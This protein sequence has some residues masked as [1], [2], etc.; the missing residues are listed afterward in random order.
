MSETARSWLPETAFSLDR[1]RRAFDAIVGGW[2]TDWFEGRTAA[3]AQV[4]F[5][6][7]AGPASDKDLFAS[8]AG[9]EL[10]IGPRAKRLL[11]ET[12]CAVDLTEVELGEIEHKLIDALLQRALDDLADRMAMPVES[13]L[14]ET[15]DV[16]MG[17]SLAGRDL[18]GIHMTRSLFT[19][20]LKAALPKSSAQRRPPL[21]RRQRALGRLNVPLRAIVGRGSL[22]LS[23]LRALALGDIVLLDQQANEGVALEVAGAGAALLY[24][25][26]GRDGDRPALNF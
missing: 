24:G 22:S 19:A 12:I 3:I 9:V 1:A 17:V 26:L 23:E 21:H 10:R 2:A 16:R 20:R 4:N 8:N 6:E 11:F 5:G 7:R 14:I 15:P 13:A 25:R 18:L